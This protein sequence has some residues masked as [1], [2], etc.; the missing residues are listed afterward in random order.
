MR[1]DLIILPVLVVAAGVAVAIYFSDRD[2]ASNRTEVKPVAGVITVSAT[3]AVAA[4]SVDGAK[5]CANT[6]C[7]L[8]GLPL[9]RELLV[10]VEAPGHN[11]WMQR[12]VIGAAEPTMS[13]HAL[14]VKATPTQD[15]PGSDSK[16]PASTADASVKGQVPKKSST[17]K[18]GGSGKRPSTKNGA[19][20]KKVGSGSGST[21]LQMAI[22]DAGRD[23][24]ILVVDVRPTWA[25]VWING[26]RVGTTPMQIAV[27][28][29]KHTVELKNEKMGYQA[30]KSITAV[31]GKKIKLS[32]TIT[33]PTAPAPSQPPAAR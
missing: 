17:K 3:P 21:K 24:A 12:L 6:P 33:T 11:V 14:L 15:A 27:P 9:D 16:P 7:R 10:T 28:A 32:G 5:R 26:K 13:V 31:K 30:K 19:K 20:E 25:E 4:V 22:V 29:G 8:A 1:W 2:P 23:Q 18:V